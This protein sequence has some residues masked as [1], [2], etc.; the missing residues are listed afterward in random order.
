L[1]DRAAK[2]KKHFKDR[3]EEKKAIVA[4]LEGEKREV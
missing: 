4:K 3:L 1:K 2:K